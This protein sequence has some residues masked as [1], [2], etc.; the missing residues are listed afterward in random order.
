MTE[1][2][3]WS[4]DSVCPKE[5]AFPLGGR[6]RE[7]RRMRGEIPGRHPLISHLR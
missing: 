5:K 3:V 7:T 4:L 1:W 6:W 2:R